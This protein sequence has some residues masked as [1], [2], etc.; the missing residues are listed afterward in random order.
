MPTFEQNL[1][2]FRATLE[3]LSRT[4]PIVEYAYRTYADLNILWRA[5]Q[6]TGDTLKGFLAGGTIGNARTVNVHAADNLN[7]KNITKE[8]WI[9]PFRHIVGGM[10]YNKVEMS[11]NNGPERRFDLAKLEW[12][13]ARLEVI[14]ELRRGLWGCPTSADDVDSIYGYLYWITLGTQGS[15]GGWTGYK[16][17]YNDGSTPG[18]EYNCA[19]LESS[20]TLNS[21]HA[22]YYADHQGK[23]DESLYSMVDDANRKLNFQPPTVFQGSE[24]EVSGPPKFVSFT[25]NN[26]I[27]VMNALN[28]KLNANVGPQPSNNGYFP[29]TGPVLPGGIPLIYVDLF[30]VNNVSIYGEDPIIGINQDLMYPV[31]LK[32]W[33]FTLTEQDNSVNHLN[34]DMFV[35]VCPQTWCEQRDRAGYMISNHPQNL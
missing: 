29:T 5:K 21:K 15:T 4:D 24:G 19:N 13:K 7:R 6:I 8:F 30:D 28:L 3:Y 35:D 32:G 18:T 11:A 23:L 25:S 20:S 14:D 16:T 33:D 22:T 27:K 31:V 26:V 17:R 34:H 10:T 9:P 2:I 1:D 12:K